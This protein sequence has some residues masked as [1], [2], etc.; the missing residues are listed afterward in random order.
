MELLSAA[1]A[2][3]LIAPLKPEAGVLSAFNF[4]RRK[5]PFAQDDR[6]FFKDIALVRD[7]ILDDSLLNEVVNHIGELEW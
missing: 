7:M 3:D 2:L 6:P 1:Q 5:I 4:I